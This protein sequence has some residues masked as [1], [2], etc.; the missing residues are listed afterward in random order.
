MKNPWFKHE[1][2]CSNMYGPVFH[3][4]TMIYYTLSLYYATHCLYI[5]FYSMYNCTIT[6]VQVCIVPDCSCKI[7]AFPQPQSSPLP[8]P[9]NSI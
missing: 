6:T 5:L 2:H 1:K 7:L 9:L 4:K 8:L 3:T